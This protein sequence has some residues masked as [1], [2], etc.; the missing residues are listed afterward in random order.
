[1]IVTLLAL[2]ACVQPTG[3]FGAATFS[4]NE[5][6]PTVINAGWTSAEGGEAYVEW[7]Y[8]DRLIQRSQPVTVEAGEQ[9][10]RL[11][12]PAAGS[13]VYVR[14]VV[15]TDDG[16]RLT[17]EIHI[18]DLPLAPAQMAR[19]YAEGAPSQDGSLLT[20]IFMMESPWVVLLNG[21]GEP[22]WYY[23]CLLYTSPSPRD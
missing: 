11:I 20:T 18:I 3:D 5:R 1:M 19:L 14:G 6:V 21:D 15:E 17:S 9:S 13:R 12:G 8:D 22:I 7:G 2:L 4:I 23:P 16:D 10:I